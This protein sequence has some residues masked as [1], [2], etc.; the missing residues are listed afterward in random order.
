[1]CREHPVH[2]LAQEFQVQNSSNLFIYLSQTQKRNKATPQNIQATPFGV[3]T[4]S[5]T[6]TGIKHKSVLYVFLFFIIHCHLILS[7]IVT[8]KY[9][10]CVACC[11][12][13]ITN[14]LQRPKRRFLNL[15]KEDMGEVGAKETNVEDRRFGERDTLWLSLIEGKGR[16]KKKK[17]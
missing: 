1:M 11:Q 2:I 8:K 17:K 9:Q 16:K 3:A 7:V 14:I 13:K 4:H 15:V 6:N 12:I 5:L 10:L